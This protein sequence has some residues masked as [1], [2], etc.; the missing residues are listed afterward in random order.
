MQ[1]KSAS[2]VQ[3]RILNDKRFCFSNGIISLPHGHPYLEELRKENINTDT[4][5]KLFKQ[6]KTI[7]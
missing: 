4:L 3:F 7:F 6:K 1:M 5:I 2:K